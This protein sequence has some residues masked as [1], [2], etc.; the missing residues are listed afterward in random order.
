VAARRGVGDIYDDFVATILP[1]PN[2]EFQPNQQNDVQDI[3]KKEQ[4]IKQQKE[5]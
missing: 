1:M 2:T 5:T 3:S 4:H